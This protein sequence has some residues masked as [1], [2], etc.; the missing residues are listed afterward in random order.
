MRDPLLMK[1]V[2]FAGGALGKNIALG[3]VQS[4]ATGS[5]LPPRVGAMPSSLPAQ[6]EFSIRLFGGPILEHQGLRLHI[7]PFHG[8]FL[9]ILAY[10]GRRGIRR[11]RLLSFLWPAGPESVLRRRLSQ[12]QYSLHQRVG[13]PNLIANVGNRFFLDVE[14]VGPDLEKFHMALQEFRVEEASHLLSL[15]FLG[16]VNPF[17]TPEMES[18]VGERIR[19]FRADIRTATARLWGEAEQ[20]G[21]WR[22]AAH[23][24]RVLL[25][26]DPSDEA[27]LRRLLRSL[28]LN[29]QVAQARAAFRE[30]SERASVESTPWTADEETRTLL[31]H[32]DALARERG[33]TFMVGR[34]GLPD[35]PPLVGRVNELA[36]LSHLLR[37]PGDGV[38]LTIGLLGEPGVGK[39]RLAW[40]ALRTLPFD[41]V[42]VLS[43][44]CSEF[45]QRIPLS[46]FTSVLKPQWV[47]AEARGLEDPWR[48][49][50]LSVFPEWHTDSGPLP[51][52]PKIEPSEVPRRLCEAFRQLFIALTRTDPVVLFIDDSHWADDTSLSV[53]D[54]I[55]HRGVEGD[56]RVLMA[57]TSSSSSVPVA[58][59][60]SGFFAVRHKGP[61]LRL[62]N[63][64]KENVETLIRL[65]AEE[66]QTSIEALD[67]WALTS[68]NPRH[69]SEAFAALQV[70]R[71]KGEPDGPLLVHLRPVVADRLSVL[72]RE[73]FHFASFLAFAKAPLRVV[74]LASAAKTTPTGA[75]SILDQ[76]ASLGW[77]SVST[78]G[79]QMN[80]PLLRQAIRDAVPEATAVL[81]HRI[82]ANT[83][84]ARGEYS[85]PWAVADH[86]LEAQEP[87]RA[88]DFAL[89]AANEA[90]RLGCFQ[91][92]EELLQRLLSVT[93]DPTGKQ[94]IA[95]HL[96]QLQFQRG[97]FNSSRIS[98]AVAWQ[99]GLR[100]APKSRRTMDLEIKVLAS[101]LYTGHLS[102]AEG[103]RRALAIQKEAHADQF[104]LLPDLYFHVL[105]SAQL[106]EEVATARDVLFQARQTLEDPTQPPANRAALHLLLSASV[107]YE[108]VESA[109]HHVTKALKLTAAQ[110]SPTAELEAHHWHLIVLY[111]L[112]YLNL[113]Q[114]I[115][116][117]QRAFR[118]AA[119]SGNILQRTRM[120]LNNAVWYLDSLQTEA[121][122]VSLSKVQ[123]LLGNDPL[124]HV[125]A[126]WLVNLGEVRLQ[127]RQWELA[128]ESFNA[129]VQIFRTVRSET[130]ELLGAAGL[131]LSCLGRRRLK[132]A[133]LFYDQ[134][135]ERPQWWTSDPTLVHTFMLQFCCQKGRP[136]KAL[137]EVEAVI[138]QVRKRS[139][140]WYLRL[141]LLTEETRA[142]EG[143]GV[144]RR[145][146]QDCE[147]QARNLQLVEI[148]RRFRGL[149]SP[150]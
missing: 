145:R 6:R 122:L 81:I 123:A 148:C 35:H 17:P 121:A 147:E 42:R 27:S 134:I 130:G 32:L 105:R 33:P 108:D 52:A 18:W 51:E 68:G 12:V 146:V 21:D 15:G 2:R 80:S 92:G 141:C 120:E 96:G 126:S 24:A 104:T 22:G 144:D 73:V 128:A 65:S 107:F 131:G 86:L 54:Y 23:L 74:D 37:E 100:T 103:W 45:E 101:D 109:L 71:T 72:S 59:H 77:L 20:R 110:G 14:K 3:S 88:R 118:A 26:L 79:V 50:L 57:G 102:P 58:L 49:I 61:C 56:L 44:R 84:I 75:A 28:G 113:P 117:R 62:T 129:A 116:G 63:L 7:S 150:R 60:R 38:V 31:G 85:A 125:R 78:D 46:P 70:A 115:E 5:R 34:F 66:L 111:H 83:L 99:L 30:F 89:A 106:R 36:T 41:G 8:L 11:G 114:G 91:E 48:A 29:G 40:E 133:E 143:L 98:L 138:Q 25:K 10:H 53:L 135:P 82:M 132:E 124:P 1:S 139:V 87:Q 64:S 136:E 43:A 67:L 55:R 69:L 119:S 9:S 95:S 142:K 39:T 94:E 140:L 127:E 16:E 137:E 76:L 19:Q 13:T 47:G 90:S 97:D 93:S 4:G 149:S 112:G